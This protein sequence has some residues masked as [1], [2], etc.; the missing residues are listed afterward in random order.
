M[1]KEPAKVGRP[2]SY[3]PEYAEKVI[4]LGKQGKSIAQISAALEV[5]RAN[6]YDW[7]EQNPEF[8]AALKLAMEYSQNWWEEQAQIHL[9]MP[10]Q[11][12]T[13]NSKLWELNVKSRF[14]KDYT[15]TTKTELSGADGGPI[16]TENVQVLALAPDDAYMKLLGK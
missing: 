13:F 6:L 16:K 2:S 1:K 10:H 12:G 3:K 8:S 11:S 5:H 9:H 4:E 7:A 15:E 14:R